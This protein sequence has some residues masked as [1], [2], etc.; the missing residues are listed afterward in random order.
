VLAVYAAPALSVSVAPCGAVV[1]RVS[2]NV[3]AIDFS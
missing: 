2:V 3:E 1:S